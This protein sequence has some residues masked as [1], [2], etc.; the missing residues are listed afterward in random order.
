MTNARSRLPRSFR[1]P[2]VAISDIG[3]SAARKP[4][5]TIIMAMVASA[6]A[7]MSITP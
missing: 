1:R 2:G 4:A 7:M 5:T 6:S 3:L